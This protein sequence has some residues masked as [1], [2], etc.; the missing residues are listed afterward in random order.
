[1]GLEAASPSQTG[2]AAFGRGATRKCYFRPP[3]LCADFGAAC[4]AKW[5]VSRQRRLK[6]SSMPLI[7]TVRGTAVSEIIDY[8]PAGPRARGFCRSAL[9]FT[10]S[11]ADLDARHAAMISSVLSGRVSSAG[12]GH[13]HRTARTGFCGGRC[14]HRVG[15]A[16]RA[17][18]GLRAKWPHA[19]WCCRALLWRTASVD[20]LGGQK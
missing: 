16:H 4:V 14:S 8:N 3:H 11:K 2:A 13:T 20:P 12:S 15:R 5:A 1:M 19:K 10:G 9:G 18:W 7:A 17:W 6:P